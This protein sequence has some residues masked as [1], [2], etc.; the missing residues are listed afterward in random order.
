MHLG[1]TAELHMML[2]VG[3]SLGLAESPKT[4]LDDIVL[5]KPNLLI[6][7]PRGFQPNL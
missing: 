3:A 4:I 7:V 5:V 1:Q 6:S 2:S